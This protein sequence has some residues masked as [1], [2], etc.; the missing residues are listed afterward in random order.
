MA[1]AFAFNYFN[2]IFNT[3]ILAP[4]EML[5]EQHSYLPK[6]GISTDSQGKTIATKAGYYTLHTDDVITKV[7]VSIIDQ[8]NVYYPEEN[9]IVIGTIVDKTY[10][11][12]TVELKGI[13][14]FNL[15]STEF[16]GATKKNKPDLEV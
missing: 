1:L 5:P 6:D 15:N 12:Y 10:E 2:F 3:M 8:S 9:D 14:F 11:Y 4:G 7:P 16:E 13:D